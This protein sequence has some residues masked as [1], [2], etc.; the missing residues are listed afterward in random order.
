LV[1]WN[2]DKAYLYQLE[3]RGVR[4]V[5]TRFVATGERVDLA[6]EVRARGWSDVILKPAISGGAFR[7][8]RFS[9]DGAAALQP[10]L[11]R[12]LGV[13]GALVQPFAP[14]ILGEG[15]WS[16]LF[17]G[18]RFSHAVLK[19]VAAGDFRVQLQYGGRYRA[20]TPAPSLVRVAETIVESLPLPPA[21]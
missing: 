14:E 5:P 2:L 19:T 11:E 6:A 9:A 17:F 4:I 18:G 12:I 3:Q 20:V 21:Y 8:H 13:G 1:R 10:E 7:T 15:E 16:L